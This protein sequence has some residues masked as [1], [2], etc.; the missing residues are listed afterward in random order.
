M[1]SPPA[2][3]PRPRARG[4]CGC[5]KPG[6]H[7]NPCTPGLSTTVYSPTLKQL[8]V[9]HPKAVR[10]PKIDCFY[11][12]PTISDQK[13][14]NSNLR[15]EPAE[16][17]IALY[18][19]ARYSQYCRVFAPMYRQITLT[20]LLAGNRETPAQLKLPLSDV[21]NAFRTYLDK[22]NH[23]RGYVL[24]GHSQGSLVLRQMIAKDVDRRPAVRKRMVSSILLGGNVLVKRGRGIGGDFKHIPACRSATQLGCVIAFSTFDQPPP[25]KSLFGRTGVPGDQVLCTNP[26]ALA[27][28]SA[29]VDPIFPSAPFAPGLIGSGIAALNLTQP[30]PNTVWSSEPGAYRAACRSAGGATALEISALGGAQVPTPSPDPTWGLHLLDANVALGNLLTVVRDEAAALARRPPTVR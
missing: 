11:V 18:Q 9:I 23:G 4:W 16:R 6:Q 27:G 30:M 13:T 19:T 14:V 8:R 25:P 22:Y 21:R 17:S 12:Y 1:R 26:A 24:I 29:K 20:A 5:A 10:N 2:R 3:A 28:G 15:V 7:P